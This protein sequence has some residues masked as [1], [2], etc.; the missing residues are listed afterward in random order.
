MDANLSKNILSI[1]HFTQKTNLLFGYNSCRNE[2]KNTRLTG[3]GCFPGII[4]LKI[5]DGLNNCMLDG[6]PSNLLKQGTNRNG[7]VGHHENWEGK[8]I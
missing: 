3:S 6:F 8:K 1:P 4:L 7:D 2:R 5:L